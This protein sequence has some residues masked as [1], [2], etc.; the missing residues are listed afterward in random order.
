VFKTDEKGALTGGEK[1]MHKMGAQETV[2]RQVNMEFTPRFTLS[3][4][5]E[6][7]DRRVDGGW[8]GLGRKIDHGKGGG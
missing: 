6:G 2:V 7:M 1:G 5:I 8:R 3:N 4:C